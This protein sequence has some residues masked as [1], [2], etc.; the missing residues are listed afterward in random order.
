MFSYFSKS[1]RTN[2]KVRTQREWS[3]QTW[4]WFKSGWQ[5]MLRM[6]TWLMLFCS[7]GGRIIYLPYSPRKV[8]IK[9]RQQSEIRNPNLLSYHQALEQ[10]SHIWILTPRKNLNSFAL[11]K[12]LNISKW[13]KSVFILNSE[14]A[15]K[16]MKPFNFYSCL[17][18]S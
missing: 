9:S 5:A 7:P 10:W 1:K 18:F 11:L 13:T 12:Y 2:G 3:V 4:F 6:A 16:N 8:K 17:K 15:G 14:I